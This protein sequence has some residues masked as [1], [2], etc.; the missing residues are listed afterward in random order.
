VTGYSRGRSGDASTIS[1]LT[2]ETGT[3]HPDRIILPRETV[4]P[5]GDEDAQ[6]LAPSE[7]AVASE[8]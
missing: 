1:E 4:L 8:I 3:V 5:S 2:D 7:G 6:V